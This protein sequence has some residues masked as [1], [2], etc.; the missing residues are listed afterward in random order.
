MSV[1]RI[2]ED[3]RVTRPYTDAQWAAIDALGHA[4]DAR[5]ARGRRARSR[6]AASRPSSAST[7]PTRRSG[8]PRRSATR[9]RERA[10][11]L[12]R[13]LHARFAPGGAAALR[14]G[15]VVPG[16]AA[17]ALG[18]RLLL[19]QGR[20]ADLGGRVALRRLAR[21][22]RVRRRRGAALRRRARE[23]PRPGSRLRAP[24]LRGRLVLPVARAAAADERRSARR[25]PRRRAGARAAGARLRARA[26]RDRG[27]RAAARARSRC[28]RTPSRA[29]AAGR[30]ILRR[31]RLYLLPGDSPIGL[32]PAARLAALGR[33]RR[34]CPSPSDVDPMAPLPPLPAR[35]AQ[36]QHA[37]VARARC[38][39]RVYAPD[40]EPL[41]RP[42]A[43]RLGARR[44]AHGALRRAARRHAA[45]V[46]AADRA[47]R[48][49]P[50]ALVQ[51]LEDTAATLR[52][53]IRIE[54]YHPPA[55]PR[56]EKFEVTPDPGRDRGERRAGLELG[57]AGRRARRC[58]TRRRGSR[59]CAPRSSCSTAATSAPA[60]AIT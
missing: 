26:R 40:A 58:S 25:A 57:R 12:L 60:A 24:G 14:P 7:R 3:P 23:A 55:D 29:G 8:T 27:L 15:Q 19:A 18:L 9:K 31:E 38:R 17:A 28:A 4:V 11:D 48:G 32:P 49:L 45:R 5:L 36:Q 46:P 6:S 43:R 10:E 42:G 56:L 41:R 35:S 33:G 2:H 53:P 34:I 50:V 20:R 22:L 54:G 51:A 13:R 39:A 1:E 59:G 47:A 52:L 21:R 30:G 44:G 16:R 37:R